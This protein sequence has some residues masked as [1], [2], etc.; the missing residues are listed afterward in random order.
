M[1]MADLETPAMLDFRFS[2]QQGRAGYYLAAS[3]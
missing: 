2:N 3:T 1:T